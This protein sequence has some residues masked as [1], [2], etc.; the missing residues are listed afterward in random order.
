MEEK[1][2]KY[3][4]PRIELMSQEEIRILQERRLR[5]KVAH[6]YAHSPF[7]RR[8]F[9]E[10]GLEPGDI[11]N[12]E[13][14]SKIPL[15]NKYEIRDSYAKSIAEGK[16]P[17]HEF[18]TVPEEDVRTIHA[19]SGT[20]GIPTTIP[21]C[22][23][24]IT[25]RTFFFQGEFI[26]RQYWAAGLRPGDI[27]AHMW[28]LGGAMIGGANHIIARGACVPASFHIL[29]PTHVGRTEK[30]LQIFKEL[31]VAAFMA[32]P[33]YAIYM[34]DY[35][36]TIGIDVKELKL[37]A[38][39]CGGE[40]GPV[41]VPGLRERLG[42]GWGVNDKVF[43][44]YGAFGVWLPYECE[45]HTGFHIQADIGFIQ[46]IDPVTKEEL[47]P[48]E[49]GSIVGTNLY[50]WEEAMP[51]I[52]FDTEDRGCILWDPCP[53][54]RTLP[55]IGSVPGRWDDMVKIKGYQLHPN[56]VE[57]IIGK[58]K[59]CAGEF[60]I[61]VDKDEE[62]KD[63][64]TIQVEYEPGIQNLKQFQ[65]DLQHSIRTVITLKANIE[66]VSKGTLGRYVMKKHRLV[67]IRTKEAKEKFE[68]GK[69]LRSADSFD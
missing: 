7:Y 31:G 8:K 51:F 5:R 35:A 68:Q 12:L 37:K 40:P 10:I 20:T 41:S 58:T 52:R 23:Q 36:K 4:D 60:L 66:M 2:R 54:G 61:I 38:V 24:E 62:G 3:W 30:I 39:I 56:A 47:K 49:Y 28:N 69:K 9:D 34:L 64:V 57:E 45:C 11:K 16:K 53:C 65:A 13:D 59:G 17:W 15:T 27:V 48:G 67:D 25:S 26:L 19:S 18:L 14:I 50:E 44:S 22:E 63:R 55:R 1:E 43:D 6:A 29:L 21:Y 32:T 33:S 42:E 46:V